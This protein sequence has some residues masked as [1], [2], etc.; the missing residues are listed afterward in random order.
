MFPVLKSVLPLTRS[1]HFYILIS[2]FQLLGLLFNSTAVAMEKVKV[3]IAQ[4]RCI[5][6]DLEGNL[7]RI[8]QMVIQAKSQGAQIVFFPETADLGWVNPEAHRLAGPVPGPFSNNISALARDN[9]IWIGVG[10]CEKDGDKLY[11]T[12]ILVNPSGEIVH[13]HRKINLL[14][15]LMD[16]P[17]TP[18]SIEG[19]QAVETPFGRIGI[20]ICA[21]SFE[22]ELREAMRRQKP[23]LVYIPYGWAAPREKWPE[24][25]FSLIKTVQKAARHIGAPVVGPNL[26]GEITH[27]PWKGQT[28]EGLSTAADR[29]GM[30]LV[31]GRWNKDDLLVIEIEPGH[32]SR[33][34]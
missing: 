9:Q 27:G 10:L 5:D 32:V 17:Y 24:H 7:E 16:P 12:A 29:T 11:D 34:K 23:D 3:A 21:D 31:Q 33:T 8:S 30:S 15:W 25:S 19:I 4:I 18:G 20:M 6:S 2:L 22:E 28:Y 1:S 14:D 13:K 26:V